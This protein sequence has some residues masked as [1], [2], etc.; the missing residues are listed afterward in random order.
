ML[1]CACT[2]LGGLCRW[3]QLSAPWC[4]MPS[5]GGTFTPPIQVF[6]KL[7][8]CSHA[9]T[10]H[11]PPT[12]PPTHTWRMPSRSAHNVSE[13]MNL[14]GEVRGKVAVLVDDMIDTA[15]TITNAA[16]VLHQ[17]GAREVYAC[18]TH[19]V[20]SPPAIARL[21][22]G[23]FQVSGACRGQASLLLC[24]HSAGAPATLT[25]A[26]GAAGRC[27]GFAGCFKRG[28]GAVI[29]EGLCSAAPAALL[30]PLPAVLA[31]N[32]NGPPL[33]AWIREPLCPITSSFLPTGGKRDPQLPT[34]SSPTLPC[35]L[36][37]R[38]DK[39]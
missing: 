11:H 21:S 37:A 12:H 22:S 34:P 27:A 19:A 39:D 25:P 8:H 31:V 5:Q 4:S 16:K 36:G 2:S 28:N 20:F 18:A 33:V 15:G 14:I 7:A 32:C 3:P 38:Y 35:Q 1:R 10:R 26:L 29:F 6:T 13:V 9:D 23:L 30:R 24:T 17:E